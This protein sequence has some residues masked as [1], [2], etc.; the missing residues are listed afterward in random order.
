MFLGKKKKDTAAPAEPVITDATYVTGDVEAVM[1]KYD[2]ESNTRIW[3]GRPKLFVQAITAA[4]AF[5]CIF[6]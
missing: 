1:K 3:E 4:F 2:K 5:Y 6:A